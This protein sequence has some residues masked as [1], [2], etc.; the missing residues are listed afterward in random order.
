MMDV[1]LFKLDGGVGTG[2]YDVGKYNCVRC[3]ECVA[4]HCCELGYVSG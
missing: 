3:V 1:Y 2:G 4:V